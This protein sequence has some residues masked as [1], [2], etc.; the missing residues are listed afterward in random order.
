MIQQSKFKSGQQLLIDDVHA[1]GIARIA[2]LS[3]SRRDSRKKI[4]WLII[5][6][7]AICLGVLT[8]PLLAS[9][10]M[11]DPKL[12]NPALEVALRS[13]TRYIGALG[14]KK[15][16]AKRVAALT[17]AGLTDEEIAR[18]HAPVGQRLRESLQAV[19]EIASE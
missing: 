18:I 8:S 16:H 15:T 2:P 7:T 10:P 13:G 9:G 4:L 1:P 19:P 12:D 5:V 14:S 6:L 3:E 11:F 17:E